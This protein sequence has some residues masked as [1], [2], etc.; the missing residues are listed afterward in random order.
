MCIFRIDVAQGSVTQDVQRHQST[1]TSLCLK[2]DD[3]EA[4]GFQELALVQRGQTEVGTSAHHP[5]DSNL[6]VASASLRCDSTLL[7]RLYLDCL[8]R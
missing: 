6:R 5:L 4:A 2:Q 3:L 7:L 1:N 8:S